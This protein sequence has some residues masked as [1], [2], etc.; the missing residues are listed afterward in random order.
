MRQLL[1]ALIFVFWCVSSTS[2]QNTGKPYPKMEV[3]A[4]Y[5]TIETNEHTF[6]FQ[7]AGPVTGQ[8]TAT[9]V[10]DFDEKGRGFE[11]GVIGNL[12]RYFGIMGD[13]AAHFSLDPF[14]VPFCGQPTC[15]PS[16]TQN[17]SINP[18][19]VEFLAG[20]EIKA[21][22]RTRLTPFAHA[23]IGVAHSSATFSTAGSILNLSA[24][25]AETGFAM[26][27]DG[28]LDVRIIR[29]VS[30]RVSIGRGRV[31]LGS[32]SLPPQRVVT[33]RFSDGVLFNFFTPE[34]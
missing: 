13:F 11:A 28:G 7:L 34:P 15:A 3:F 1:L 25:D 4:G 33:A 5:S 32:N 24:T 8:Q 31:Y 22:N 18:R 6:Q 23:L 29:R 10:L 27:F 19:L 9:A 17:G 14:P 16:S 20:P 12:N 26:A 21:R 30:L 2:A